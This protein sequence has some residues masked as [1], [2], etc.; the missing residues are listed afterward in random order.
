[1]LK[2]SWMFLLDLE[3]HVLWLF[4]FYLASVQ[5]I[6]TDFHLGEFNAF[7]SVHSLDIRERWQNSYIFTFQLF[8]CISNMWNRND[9]RLVS[10]HI[11]NDDIVQSSVT[12]S[13]QC[14]Y[15]DNNIRVKLCFKYACREYVFVYTV[16]V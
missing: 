12:K 5:T 3:L 10:H 14:S 7:T 15:A 9:S 4:I 1:M 2:C 6:L 13:I 11:P 16:C 8:G